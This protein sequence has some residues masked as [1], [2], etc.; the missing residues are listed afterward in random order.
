MT[1][2][3]DHTAVASQPA[4]WSRR[5]RLFLAGLLVVFALVLSVFDGIAGRSSATPGGDTQR[6][7]FEG[8]MDIVDSVL[9]V[10]FPLILAF[11]IYRQAT[12]LAWL[13]TVAYIAL[14]LIY[15][16]G[17]GG[18]HLTF[19]MPIALALS[20]WQTLASRKKRGTARR[21]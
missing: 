15:G 14:A 13:A 3:A 5:T 4:N 21:E 18:P 17:E 7:G 8:P 16:F 19:G 12:W 2:N 11:A 20:I 1:V 10:L 9:F 6:H